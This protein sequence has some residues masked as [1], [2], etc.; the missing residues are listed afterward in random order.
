MRA[1]RRRQRHRI[2]SNGTGRRDEFAE[3]KKYG[4]LPDELLDWASCWLVGVLLS[5]LL[6]LAGSARGAS[7]GERANVQARTFTSY[8]KLPLYFEANRGQAPGDFQFLARG[9][10]YTF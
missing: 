2:R 4:K 3:M 7:A 5:F 8:G 10:G 6:L 1:N 9:R